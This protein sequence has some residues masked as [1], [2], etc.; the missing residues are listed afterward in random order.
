MYKSLHRERKEYLYKKQQEE[1]EENTRKRKQSVKNSLDKNQR[2]DGSLKDDALK[3]QESLTYDDAQTANKSTEDRSQDDE[4]RWAGVSDPKIALTTS[5]SPSPRLKN[6]ASEMKHLLPN[7]SRMNRG[8]NDINSLVHVA[9]QE[10][11]SDLVILHETRGRPDGLIISHLPY[12]PTAYFTLYN[13]ML[14]RDIP[15]MPKMSLQY[16]HLVAHGFESKLGSRVSDILR[17]L[18]PVPKDDSSRLIT[19]KNSDDYI[20]MRHHTYKLEGETS[21]RKKKDIVLSEAGPRF[22]LRPYKII[23]GTLDEEATAKVEWQLHQY[24]NTAKKKRYM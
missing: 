21:D 17:F 20:S 15:D 12:G 19:F 16:P 18:F 6:F 10:N 2:I 1:K 3:L 9:R 23:L 22:E 5:R 4:Y 7:T 11:F 14:R 24:T 8:N 13:V